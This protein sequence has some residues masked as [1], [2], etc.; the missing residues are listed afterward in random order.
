MI[1]WTSFKI[2]RQFTDEIKIYDRFLNTWPPELN[3]MNKRFKK[4]LKKNKKPNSVILKLFFKYYYQIL[5]NNYIFELQ[6][7]KERLSFLFSNKLFFQLPDGMCIYYIKLQEIFKKISPSILSVSVSCQTTYG[8]CCVQDCL[9]KNFGFSIIFHYGH[10]CLVSIL[11]CTI[12]VLYIFIEIRYDFSAL[13]EGMK[14]IFYDLKDKITITSTIQFSSELKFIKTF[15]SKIFKISQINQ[16][17][18]L[19][20]GELLGCTSFK[21]KHHSGVVYIGDGKFHVESVFFFN[22]NIKIIQFNPFTKSLILLGF[23]FIETTNEREFV[24]EKAIFFSKHYNFIFGTLGRQGNMKILRVLAYMSIQKKMNCH[25][26][27]ATEIN[28]YR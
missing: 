19:S 6:K 10:S 3:I 11:N 7:T 28:N 20:P 26:Y 13:V 2:N 21:T 17:K 16:T 14:S 1:Q 25:T 5:P 9:A 4:N 27:A 15:L 24:I 18:P 23:K 12:L 22:P 8:A